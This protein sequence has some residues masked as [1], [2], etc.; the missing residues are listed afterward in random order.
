[1]IEERG[2][3]A[4][5]D[6]APGRISHQLVPEGQSDDGAM[7]SDLDHLHPDPPA[8]RYV[9]DHLAPGRAEQRG[10]RILLGFVRHTGRV[11][12][13]AVPCN[14]TVPVAAHASGGVAGVSRG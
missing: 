9:V 6:D 10:Q 2:D 4:A 14:A 11:A 7:R 13:S 5:E 12:R 1:M 8:V 3:H